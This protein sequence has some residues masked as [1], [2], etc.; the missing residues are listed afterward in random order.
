[1]SRTGSDLLRVLAPLALDSVN[2]EEILLSLHHLFRGIKEDSIL[3]LYHA[4]SP[5]KIRIAPLYGESFLH[6]IEAARMHAEEKLR[7]YVEALR[8]KLPKVEVSYHVESLDVAIS[9]EEILSY[10]QT[11]KFSLLVVVFKQ[12]KRW[13]RFFGSTA[14]WDILEGSPISVLLLSAPLN[15][16]PKRILW[17]TSMQPES[18]ALLKPLIQL[19]HHLKGTLYCAKVNTP[20]AFTTQRVFQRQVLEMCDYIIDHIDPDFVPEECLLYADKDVVE[21]LLHVV[22]DFLMDMVAIDANEAL[23]EWKMVDKLL[24]HQ[25]PVLFLKDSK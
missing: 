8:N 21:G 4:L 12:R 25:I 13:E 2:E 6:Q 15:I 14:L 11:E 18:F 7:S 3:R 10:L 20:G 5:D 17:A 16:P 1:M 24:N 19:I 23:E 22:Q 9:A